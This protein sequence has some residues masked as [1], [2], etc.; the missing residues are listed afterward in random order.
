MNKKETEL[1]EAA[2]NCNIFKVIKLLEEGFK[3]EER[4]TALALSKLADRKLKSR[5]LGGNSITLAQS[6]LKTIVLIHSG[7]NELLNNE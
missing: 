5:Q 4:E 7:I 6:L 2:K 1:L 3:I